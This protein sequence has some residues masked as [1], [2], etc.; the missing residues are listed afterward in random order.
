MQQIAVEMSTHLIRINQITKQCSF[1]YLFLLSKSEND[2][3]SHKE[4]RKTPILRAVASGAGIIG[5]IFIYALLHFQ[6]LC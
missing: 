5:L 4:D 3:C 2:A 1:H 6:L